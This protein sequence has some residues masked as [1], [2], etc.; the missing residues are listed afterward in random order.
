MKNK[1]INVL[2]VV[3]CIYWCICLKNTEAYYFPYIIV[4]DVRIDRNI[5]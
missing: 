2:K 1:I 3:F 5:L 4:G